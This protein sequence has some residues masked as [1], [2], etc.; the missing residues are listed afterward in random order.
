MQPENVPLGYYSHINFAFASIN[1]L[2]YTI[3]DMAPD[4][5]ALYQRV[6]A[7]KL[8]QPDLQVWLSIGGWSFNDPGPTANTFSN[9]AGSTGAQEIFFASLISFLKT[10]NF[11]GVDLDW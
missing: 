4:V 5:G 9:L 11:D 2:L 6:S 7:L 3:E 10:N 1:P 8:N